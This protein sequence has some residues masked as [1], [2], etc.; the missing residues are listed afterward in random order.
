MKKTATTPMRKFATLLGVAA[1]ALVVGFGIPVLWLLIAAQLQGAAGISRMTSTT[2]ATVFPGILVTYGLVL[3][4]V[5]WVTHRRSAAPTPRHTRHPWLQSMRDAPTV[6]AKAAPI[7]TAFMIAAVLV[8]I[9][10]GI[11]FVLWAGNPLPPA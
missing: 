4:A 3:Y 10:F 2:A 7:E 9:A 11:W 1:A 6:P 8:T 5:G